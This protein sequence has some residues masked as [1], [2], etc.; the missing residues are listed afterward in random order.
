MKKYHELAKEMKGHN[1]AKDMRGKSTPF[2]FEA[3]DLPLSV[4]SS[5][6]FYAFLVQNG[7]L[8]PDKVRSCL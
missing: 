6:P 1:H 8:S 4:R 3:F 7:T 2:S 5:L